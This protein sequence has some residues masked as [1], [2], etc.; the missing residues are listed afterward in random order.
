[1]ADR[2]TVEQALPPPTIPLAGVYVLPIFL[3]IG[4]T[5]PLGR[6]RSAGSVGQLSS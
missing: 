1:M 6:H 3:P 4:E 2:R 5:A